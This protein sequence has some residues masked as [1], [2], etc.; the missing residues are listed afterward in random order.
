[1]NHFRSGPH[2]HV[3]FFSTTSH[4]CHNYVLNKQPQWRS[5]PEL[6]VLIKLCNNK[7][8]NNPAQI[9]P[10]TLGHHSTHSLQQ[11]HTQSQLC[12]NIAIIPVTP[13]Q[14]CIFTTTVPGYR[15]AGKEFRL[16]S[17]GKAPNQS[18]LAYN[19]GK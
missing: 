14:V 9:D 6:S 10:I 8:V 7:S 2:S 17:E 1:M 12:Q 19:I 4:S 3:S 18:L 5:S 13:A 15:K 16:H 11:Y